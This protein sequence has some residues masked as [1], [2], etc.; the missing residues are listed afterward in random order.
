MHQDEKD[1]AAHICLFAKVVLTSHCKWEGSEYF[2]PT[3]MTQK[4]WHASMP[5]M[6]SY[7]QM[8]KK[9]PIGRTYLHHPCLSLTQTIASHNAEEIV[10][11][12]QFRSHLFFRAKP[13]RFCLGI[14]FQ[15]LYWFGMVIVLPVSLLEIL[16]TQVFSVFSDQSA[17][18]IGLVAQFMHKNRYRK[19]AVESVV[20]L[21]E[22]V[23]MEAD[24]RSAKLVLC[25]P[26]GWMYQFPSNVNPSRITEIGRCWRMANDY[27]LRVMVVGNT[28]EC[29]PAAGCRQLTVNDMCMNGRVEI[30]RSPVLKVVQTSI[31]LHDSSK[32]VKPRETALDGFGIVA[33]QRGMLFHHLSLLCLRDRLVRDNEV[34]AF[35]GNP[36]GVN[37]MVRFMK[38]YIRMIAQISGWIGGCVVFTDS[39][40]LERTAFALTLGVVLSEMWSNASASTIEIPVGTKY[41]SPWNTDRDSWLRFR[42]QRDNC[43]TDL[44]PTNCCF[45]LHQPNGVKTV[46]PLR[47]DELAILHGVFVTLDNYALFRD[48]YELLAAELTKSNGDDVCI[49]EWDTVSCHEAVNLSNS[50][51][52]LKPD[53]GSVIRGLPVHLLDSDVKIGCGLSEATV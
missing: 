31:Q 39:S 42:E 46:P 24:I 15:M 12:L 20:I 2:F 45:L 18:Q 16:L 1:R 43:S 17:T 21:V 30:Q 7:Y 44:S 28:L 38:N 35:G 53:C 32:D 3:V 25:D 40:L 8:S 49:G 4:R 11:V 36:D 19:Y 29:V 9:G 6:T 23:E 50:S 26:L 14:F 5:S 47:S 13:I 48:G 51:I 33:L 37:P 34:R 52:S 27:R 10:R 22:D 41:G